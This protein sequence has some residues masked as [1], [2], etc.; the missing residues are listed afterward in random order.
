[1]LNFFDTLV[2]LKDDKMPQIRINFCKLASNFMTEFLTD[3][4]LNEKIQLNTIFDSLKVDLDTN[5]SEAA[6]DAD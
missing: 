6:F 4:D 3:E 5:V 2:S 1:L